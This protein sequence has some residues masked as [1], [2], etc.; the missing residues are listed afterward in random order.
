MQFAHR[1]AVLQCL[2]SHANLWVR[3][4][5]TQLQNATM[6][7]NHKAKSTLE[8][9]AHFNLSFSSTYFSRELQRDFRAANFSAV[10]ARNRKTVPL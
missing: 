9:F 6:I 3:L 4:Q 2:H 5:I 1:N 7:H 8:T 10:R